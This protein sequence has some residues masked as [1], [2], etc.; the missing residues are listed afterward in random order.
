CAIEKPH[1]DFLFEIFDLAGERGLRKMQLFRAFCK[2][3]CVRDR[4][5]V[6][7]VTQFHTVAASI[8]ICPALKL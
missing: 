7:K 3:K 1:A 6:S 2:A 4:H 8:V 5:K